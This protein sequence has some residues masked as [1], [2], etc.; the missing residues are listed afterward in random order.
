M[1]HA[2]RVRTSA[3]ALLVISTLTAC[4]GGGSGEF[5]SSPSDIRALTG[6]SAPVETPEAQAARLPAIVQRTDSLILSTIY[7]DSDDPALPAELRIRAECTGTRCTLTEPTTGFTDTVSLSDFEVVEGETEAIGTRHGITVM[8]A[9]GRYMGLDYLDFG[10]WM[11]HGGFIIN[12]SDRMEIGGVAIETRYAL[13]GGDLTGN[14]PAGAA[15]WLGIMVGTPATGSHRGDRLQ[16]DAALSYDFDAGS[17]DITF[18]DIKNV[19]RNTAHSAATVR[20]TD[21]PVDSQ[22]AFQAGPTGNRVQGGFYGPDHVEAA[23]VF[24]QSNIV[25]AFGASRHSE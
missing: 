18:S 10:A 20:F 15:T 7:G 17:L 13:A 12:T 4:G 21:V 9:A 2:T 1:K 3:T 6:V 8:S 5:R 19:D 24:E 11:H 25:G 14:A 22:G 23:G 16:G